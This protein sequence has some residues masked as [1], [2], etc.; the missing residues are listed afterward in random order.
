MRLHSYVRIQ[1]VQST[2]R[3]FAAV[4]A[5]LIHALN[6]LVTASRSLVLLGTWNRNE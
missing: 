2:I 3:F 1:M 6:F 5:A 4:P